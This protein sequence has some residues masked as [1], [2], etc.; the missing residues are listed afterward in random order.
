MVGEKNYGV[1]SIA[2]GVFSFFDMNSLVYPHE[3]KSIHPLSFSIDVIALIIWTGAIQVH[4][5]TMREPSIREADLFR[6][7][8]QRT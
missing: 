7:T 5:T 1:M 8:A 6:P 4:I 3:N 2:K